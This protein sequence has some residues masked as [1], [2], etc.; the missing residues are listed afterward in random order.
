MARKILHIDMDC[1]YA[2]V[3]ERENPALKGKPVGVSGNS[4][5]GVLTTANYEARK[6]GCRSAMPVFMAKEKC[7]QLILVPIRFE[8]YREESRKIRSILARFTEVIEPLSLDEAYLDVSELES[9]GEAVA[10]E[11]RNQIREEL[12]ITASAGIAPNKMLA[13]VASDWK[14]PDGQFAI[15]E[16]EVAEF[17]LTLPVKKIPGV[18]KK[19]AAR[20]LELSV[21]TCG[22]LQRFERVDLASRFGKWGSEL[23]D[24][25]RGQDLRPVVVERERKS[26]SNET[27]FRENLTSLEQLDEALHPMVRELSESLQ[28]KHK[29]RRIKSLVVKL[30]F[31]DFETTT[32]ERAGNGSDLTVFT[33]LLAEA[34]GRGA[35]RAVRLL[36][37]GVKFAEQGSDSQMELGL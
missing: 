36:G 20:L 29:E 1:F 23:Y 26:V 2:A 12:R 18:G 30:K 28:G 27:T 19:M 17:M 8:L 32:A 3:E 24:L 14:K 13:K 9:S 6:F 4:M 25:C 7:P 35:G 21:S 22:D 16:E 5:R 34:W 33:V 11:I 15:H 37:V 31:A 10:R